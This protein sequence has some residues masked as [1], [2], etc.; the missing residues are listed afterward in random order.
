MTEKELRRLSRADLLQMLIE[1]SIE[2]QRTQEKAQM[3]ERE[4]SSRSIIID[5]AG[6]IAEASLQLN[7][8]FEAA[9][10][11]CTQYVENIRQL[12]ARQEITC[13]Q[14]EAESMQQAEAY[15]RETR[16]QCADME[17]ETERQCADLEARTLKRCTA[18]EADAQESCEALLKQAKAEAARI[19]E[20]AKRNAA[21]LNAAG[22]SDDDEASGRRKRRSEKKK[23][24]GNTWRW[25]ITGRTKT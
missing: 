4:L 19:L 24:K 20:E 17:T 3:L 9:Q 13:R 1:Q 16:R 22:P 2:L 8:V 25:R 5:N 21:A 18:M 14:R 11:S 12:N 6:S 15:L 23:E 10:A 7:N